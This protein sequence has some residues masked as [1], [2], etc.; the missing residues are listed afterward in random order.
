[1]E[2]IFSMTIYDDG[3]VNLKW[4]NRGKDIAIPARAMGRLYQATM[5]TLLLEK[6]ITEKEKKR[7]RERLIYEFYDGMISGD[8]QEQAEIL[9]FKNYKM[10]DEQEPPRAR[11]RF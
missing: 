11:R 9:A 5:K 7:I 1:M 6:V 2:K 3:N 8:N 10:H 4:E